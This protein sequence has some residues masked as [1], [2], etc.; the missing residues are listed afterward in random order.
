MDK[1]YLDWLAVMPP[2]A[3]PISDHAK[4]EFLLKFATEW[5]NYQSTPVTIISQMGDVAAQILRGALLQLIPLDQIRD[6]IEEYLLSLVPSKIEM[7][8]GF[9]IDLDENV[10][11]YTGGVFVPDEKGCRLQTDMRM[12]IDLGIGGG[13]PQFDMRSQGSIGRFEIKLIGGFDAVTLKFSGASFSAAHDTKPD[14]DLDYED[15]AIGDELAFFSALQNYLSPKPGSGF[16]ITPARGFPGIEAGYGL[17]IGTISFGTMSFFNVSLNAAAI[18]PFGGKEEARFRTSVSTRDAPFTVSYAPFG[19]SGFFAIEATGKGVQTFEASLEFG[20]A[21]AFG[22]GPLSGQGRIMAGF[23]IRV[24]TVTIDVNGR[25]ETVKLTE[26]LGTFYAGGSASIWI[27]S[28]SASFSVRL[29]Q[30]SDGGMIGE[31]IYTFSFSL[32]IKDFDFSIPVVKRE[33][34]QSNGS[35]DNSQL[36]RELK[37]SAV[38]GYAL[39]SKKQCAGYGNKPAKVDVE[40]SG[41][42]SEW[43]SYRKYFDESI[44]MEGYF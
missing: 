31:A 15:Y 5:G 22:F 23:Y 27:F 21:G 3:G 6:Q 1:L 28:A 4:R 26:I 9:G 37:M 17:N 16:Y 10:A 20:L 42:Y 25:P 33:E 34:K 7:S 30:S 12:E 29:G 44:D 2:K 38:T 39:D 14:F 40:A 13:G 32:G 24:D 8:Y 36:D 43:R 11:K 18:L 35:K 41:S 19:G